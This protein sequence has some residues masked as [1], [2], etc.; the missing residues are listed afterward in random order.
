MRAPYAQLYLHCAWATWERLPLI[1]PDIEEPIYT[2][3]P[4]KWKALKCEVFA[5]GGV[6]DHVH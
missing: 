3:I 6:P 1:T 5:I 4:A 2:S